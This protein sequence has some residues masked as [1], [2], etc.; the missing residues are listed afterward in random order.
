MSEDRNWLSVAEVA[1][2]FDVSRMTIYRRI[3]RKEIP[4]FRHGN[5][6]RI[7]RRHVA[8]FV[9]QHTTR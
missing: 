1:D 6:I 5:V 3:K 9:A 4:S 2:L 7:H 8:A